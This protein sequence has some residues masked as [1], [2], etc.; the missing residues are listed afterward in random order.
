MVDDVP[1]DV[2]HSV[3]APASSAEDAAQAEQLLEH[4]NVSLGQLS[5]RQQQIFILSRLHGCSY[6]E[7][8]D[9]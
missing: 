4:L 2:L 6:Q 8:A 7:I 5:P 1:L 3:A 9:S